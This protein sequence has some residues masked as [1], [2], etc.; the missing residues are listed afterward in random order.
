MNIKHTRASNEYLFTQQFEV[1]V[2]DLRRMEAAPG[3]PHNPEEGGQSTRVVVP[4]ASP[5]NEAF[6]LDRE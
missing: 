2:F 3:I 6:R 5:R 1:R 4:V